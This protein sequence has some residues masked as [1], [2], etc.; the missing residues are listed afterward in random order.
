MLNQYVKMQVSQQIILNKIGNFFSKT[1][2]KHS[3]QNEVI[4]TAEKMTNVIKEGEFS[5][6]NWSGYPLGVPKPN[7]PF[8]I[9]KG[10][11]Y[12]L[13]RKIANN[14]NKLIHEAIP[15]LHGKA[16]HEINPVKFGGSPTDL[17]NKIPLTKSEHIELTV[18]WNALLKYLEKGGLE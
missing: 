4:T 14:T 15:S 7:G 16:I 12:E 1:F 3:T 5:I 13:A 10:S 18:W 6:S 9:I 11:E 17:Y 8:R 2:G